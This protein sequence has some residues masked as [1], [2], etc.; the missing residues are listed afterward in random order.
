MVGALISVPLVIVAARLLS[1]RLVDDQRAPLVALRNAMTLFVAN[2]SDLWLRCGAIV[3]FQ[4]LATVACYWA[5]CRALGQQ[6]GYAEVGLPRM[7]GGLAN[8]FA[9]TPQGVGIV[10][11][12]VALAGRSFGIDPVA[13]VAAVVLGRAV[14]MSS[15]MP[16]MAWVV[17]G[18]IRRRLF[19]NTEAPEA[20]R[21]SE[22]RETP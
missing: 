17:T 21:G 13:A 1:K 12:V 20:S 19:T 15:L 3:L 18:A 11:G 4:C 6:I 5:V 22:T 10:E 7:A 16:V 2:R 9:I 8:I 14:A